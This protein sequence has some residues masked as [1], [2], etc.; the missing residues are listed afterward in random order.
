MAEPTAKQRRMFAKMG[1]AM[2]DGSYYIRNADDLQN[3]IES[4]GRA[5][6][7]AGESDVARRNAVRKHI[8]QRADALK[9]SSKIPDTWNS[10]G[11]LKQSAASHEAIGEEFIAHFGRKGMKW[12]ERVF[13]GGSSSTSSV[14]PDVARARA[15]QA[16]I[17]KHG[18]S[19]L[20]NDQLRELNKRTQLEAD[21]TRL[22]APHVSEGRKLVEQ[23]AKEQGK[24]IASQ[25]AAKYGPKGIE[26]VAKHAVKA[27][28]STGKHALN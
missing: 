28:V 13:G 5:T 23:I 27:V 12:G 9:L 2:P 20:G 3:A 18:L 10:D 19:A 24:Q 17:Q 4:V 25:Y 16:I 21:H 7:N 15:A 1:I 6:P 11:S 22:N 14:H 8:I 26:W